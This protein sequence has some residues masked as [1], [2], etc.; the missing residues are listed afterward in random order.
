MVGIELSGQDRHRRRRSERLFREFGLPLPFLVAPVRTH[1][2]EKRAPRT[3][4]AM[5]ASP[6]LP[7]P[8][9]MTILIYSN[10]PA[11]PAVR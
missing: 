11:K 1:V 3:R 8:P 5:R 2:D 4:G 7:A 6:A 10:S 9:G